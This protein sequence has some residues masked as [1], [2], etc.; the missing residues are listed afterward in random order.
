MPRIRRLIDPGRLIH[1]ISRFVNREYLLQMEEERKEYLTRVGHAFRMS[2]WRALSF[3][4]MSSHTHIAAISGVVPFEDIGR[5]I[6]S[7]FAGWYNRRHG[8]LGPVFASRP[9][10]YDVAI[11]GVANLIAYQHNNPVRAGVVPSA[12]A[13]SWTSHRIYIGKVGR[14]DWLHSDFGLDL[15]GF[16]RDQAGRQSFDKFVKAAALSKT[17][18]SHADTSSRRNIRQQLGTAVEISYAELNKNGAVDKVPVW[19]RQGAPLR[20][21]RN[22]KSLQA[23]V[24][25]VATAEN[26]SMKELLSKSRRR[27]VVN[28][29]RLAVLCCIHIGHPIG[30]VA[31]HLGI[32]NVAARKL[33]QT[34]KQEVYRK[35]ETIVIQMLQ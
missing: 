23:V 16:R 4:L 9:A 1:I 26:L 7:G 3:A 35:A 5:R 8:R 18:F 30:E 13:S 11:E 21:A 15:C 31:A 25:T 27:K 2:D 6:N 17:S 34:A 19:A 33:E 14:L 24:E 28:V 29:R 22:T 20:F 12:E 32:T 10:T